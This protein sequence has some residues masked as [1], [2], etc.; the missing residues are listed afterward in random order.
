MNTRGTRWAGPEHGF[1]SPPTKKEIYPKL[2]ARIKELEATVEE[3]RAEKA[4]LCVKELE[5]E[6][7]YRPSAN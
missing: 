5:K 3:L 7:Y 4:E 1:V 2:K 6:L